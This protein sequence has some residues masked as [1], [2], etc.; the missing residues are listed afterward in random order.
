MSLKDKTSSA[1][2]AVSDLARARAFYGG[3]LG[4][5]EG[6]EAEPSVASYRT[7]NTW[8]VVYQSE[9]VRPGT[10]NAVASSAGG[11]VEAIA[12][13]LRAKGVSLE[14]YPEL[15]MEIERGVHRSGDFRGIWFKDP[16]GNILHVN[17]M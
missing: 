6:D 15:G 13:D 14:E 4:L 9:N 12:D 16:T 5:K 2:V 11:D 3:M 10:G 8:L 17:S 7:G 1:I